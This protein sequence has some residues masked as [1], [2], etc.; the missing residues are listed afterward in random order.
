MKMDYFAKLMAAIMFVLI[1]L[2]IGSNLDARM[3]GCKRCPPC[4][5]IMSD[6]FSPTIECFPIALKDQETNVCRILD[7]PFVC[8]VLP[9]GRFEC[10]ERG[11]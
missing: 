5:A 8:Y 1:G 6:P 11:K 3:G 4:E 10:A 9:G 7:D 2:V